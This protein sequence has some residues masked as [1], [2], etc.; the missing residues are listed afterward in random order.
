[1]PWWYFA[2]LILA[3][4][5]LVGFLIYRRMAAKDED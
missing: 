1:M 5:G 2:I 3:A 4:G